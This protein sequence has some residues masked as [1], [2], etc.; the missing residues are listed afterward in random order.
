MNILTSDRHTNHNISINSSNNIQNYS[1]THLLRTRNTKSNKS[2]N[3]NNNNRDIDE[4]K[5]KSI[6][7][8]HS[9]AYY[10][11]KLHNCLNNHN[12]LIPFYVLAI[13]GSRSTVV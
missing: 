11:P 5:E 6:K 9:T 3:N 4:R 13:G 1:E 10:L 12:N 2:T 8:I 7:Y